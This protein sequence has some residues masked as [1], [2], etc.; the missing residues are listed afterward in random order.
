MSSVFPRQ[1]ISPFPISVLSLRFPISPNSQPTVANLSGFTLLELLVV[2]AVI[3]ILMVLV[4]PAFTNIK[5]GN[6]ITGAAYTVSGMLEQARSYAMG[7]STYVWVGFYEEDASRSS[8]SPATAGVG[9]IV[10]SV[11]A[12]KDGTIV[13]D[14]NNLAAIDPT[15]LIQ[16]GKLS[17]IDNAHLASFADGTGSGSTFDTRPP[18]TYGT[19]RIGDTTPPNASLTPFQYPVGNPAAA[20]QYTFVKAVQL[21][22]TGEARIDNDNYTLKTVA[23]IGLQST[24]GPVVDVS[25]HNDIAIQF[26]AISGDTK[27]YRR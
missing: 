27:I 13:Y 24:H 11:V 21:S 26:S 3:S 19:A 23:E 20:P 14:L 8:T 15:R 12:S 22:P 5:R 6:D 4:A 10:M 1:R 25:N 2:I 17:K 7:N 9:R 18:V 16:L